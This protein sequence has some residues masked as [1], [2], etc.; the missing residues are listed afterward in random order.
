MAACC[1]LA[2]ACMNDNDDWKTP[3][4]SESSYGNNALDESNYITIK[5]LIDDHKAAAFSSGSMDKITDDIQVRGF[6]T[7]NDVGGNYYKKLTIE[8]A[9]AAITIDID[10]SG[11]WGYLPLGQEVLVNLKDLYIGGYGK[12]PQIGVPYVSKKGVL[13]IGRMPKSTWQKHFKVLKNNSEVVPTEFTQSFKDNMDAN[14]GKLVIFKNVTFKGADGKKTLKDGPESAL[15]GYFQTWLNEWGTDVV[16]YTSG[17]YAKF[18]TFVLP[19]DDATGKPIACD[20][21]GVATRY[22]DTWQISIRHA[23]D[24]IVPS[25]GGGGG[26]GGTA[27]LDIDFT[28]GIGDWDIKDVVKPE[29]LTYVWQQST[30]YGMK[31]SAF[32]NSTRYA[33]DSWLVSPSFTLT[34]AATMTFSQAQRYSASGCTDLHVMYST[35]YT[36]GDINAS[37]WTEVTPSAWPDGSSWNFIDCTAAIPATAKRVAFRYTSTDTTAGTWEIKT[38]K[39]E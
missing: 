30:Q 7:G 8:D 2:T 5:K 22:N 38:V 28:A 12:M 17:D 18:S 14:C 19:Y 11:L 25:Q 23:A 9:T 1:F 16:F 26:G 13:G 15:A 3:S 24:L 36:G 21:V 35:T 34:A 6:V 20:I 10:E 27:I 32:A 31:A 29:A 4:H 33:T 39:I 37:E